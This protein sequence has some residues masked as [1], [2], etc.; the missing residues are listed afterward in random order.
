MRRV[1]SFS[2]PS[3]EWRSEFTVGFEILSMRMLQHI[4]H[5]ITNARAEGIDSKIAF[6][7][8]MTFGHGNKEH[9]KTA[10]YFRCCNLDLYP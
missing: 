7:G 2:V 3:A 5:H 10:M 4:R 1:Q 9:M 8:K 6:I